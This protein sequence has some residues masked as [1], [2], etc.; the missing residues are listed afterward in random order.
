[1]RRFFFAIV[2]L[3]T[4]S[5]LFAWGRD[6]HQIVAL[7]AAAKV[8]PA[9]TTALTGLLGAQTLADIAPLPDDWRA[10]EKQ[11]PTI[12][13]RTELWHF[14]DIPTDKATYDQNRDCRPIANN[15]VDR[16]CIIAAIAHF[17]TVLADKTAPK[18]DRLRALTF[19]VHF[20][21]DVHQPLHSTS[22]F[23]NG[24]SDH[25]GNGVKASFPGVSDPNQTENLHH[26]WDD[27]LIASEGRAQT[28]YVQHLLH[29]VLPTL[30]AAALNETSV[31]AWATSAHQHAVSDAYAYPGISKTFAPI[32]TPYVAKNTKV[33][34]AQLTL[35][36][37][38]LA[39]LLDT[40]L[41]P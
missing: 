40:L 11:H 29:D 38:H 30:P 23:I 28:V 27:D 6:G 39:H 1:M 34:D 33:A 37:I 13:P 8:K 24:Q 18:A 41:A 9:T 4:P 16:N 19:I 25:G 21:G 36:G 12:K 7:V 10:N 5:V 15:E 31:V 20:A 14:V 3:L 2:V 32:D 26:V 17:Q 35:A 22:R